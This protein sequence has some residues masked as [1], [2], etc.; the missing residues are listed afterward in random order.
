[1]ENTKKEYVPV[2]N[3]DYIPV[4][5]KRVINKIDFNKLT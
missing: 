5:V 2:I 1:M 4:V 3:D